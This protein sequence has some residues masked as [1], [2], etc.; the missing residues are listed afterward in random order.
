MFRSTQSRAIGALLVAA[1]LFGATFVVIKSAIEDISPISFVAWRFLLGAGL[2]ALFAI[3]KGR[4]IWLHGSIAGLALFSG[5]ALQTSGLALTSA[6][7]SALITGLYVVMT[8]FLASAFAR[9]APSWWIAGAAAVSFAGLILLTGAS[10]LSF[11]RGD[12]LT[13]G[14]ALAFGLHIV[15]LSRY[16]RYHPVIPFTVVQLVV[17]AA[18]AFFLSLVIDGTTA[19]PPSST[20]AA[21]ALTGFG[22]SAGAFILQIWAQTIIGASATALILAS[23]SAFGVATAWIVLDERLA[24]SGWLGGALILGAIFVVVIKQRDRRSTEAE[25]VTP[26]H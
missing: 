10:G 9:R 20:W 2:L 21:L 8:P 3:P 13:L 25:A 1:F 17:T 7:N 19:M 12:V 14:C 24:A 4:K 18:L 15:A 22:V 23:E 11:E 5:Y 6:S 26:A 16:A